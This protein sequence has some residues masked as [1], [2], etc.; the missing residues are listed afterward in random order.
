L[1][2]ALAIG[3]WALVVG[4]LARAY[5]MLPLVLIVVFPLVASLAHLFSSFLVMR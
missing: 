2:L 3:A 1:A 4:R 5:A